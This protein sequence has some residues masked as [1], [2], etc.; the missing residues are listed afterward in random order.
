MY[1]WYF[2]LIYLI[3]LKTVNCI[4]FIPN[5]TVSHTKALPSE[6]ITKFL[7]K[8]EEVLLTVPKTHAHLQRTGTQ[9]R[10]QNSKETRTPRNVFENLNLTGT[11][12]PY[13]YIC[14]NKF[15]ANI[16]GNEK[17]EIIYSISLYSFCCFVSNESN[18][19]S[20]DQVSI[21]G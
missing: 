19:H 18:T 15:V 14:E 10:V 16:T 3:R 21:K 9:S 7:D 13:L 6:E 1:M 8:L 4:I 5:N 20:K 17:L 12:I 2:T 11:L